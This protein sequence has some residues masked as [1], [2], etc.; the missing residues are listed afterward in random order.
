MLFV[1]WP[2]TYTRLPSLVDYVETHDKI[3]VGTACFLLSY[4]CTLVCIEFTQS[5]GRGETLIRQQ[6][7]GR[8]RYDPSSA[9]THMFMGSPV[10]AI[11][12][13]YTLLTINREKYKS[14][15]CRF[16]LWK[17]SIALCE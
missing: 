2:I 8:T 3:H 11:S 7:E 14:L 9:T 12:Y 6:M 17:T 15:Q 16:A 4:R 13:L 10:L 1:V 5:V